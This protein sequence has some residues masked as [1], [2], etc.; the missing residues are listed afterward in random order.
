MCCDESSGYALMPPIWPSR[1]RLWDFGFGE[2]EKVM[3]SV[4]TGERRLRGGVVMNEALNSTLPTAL[5]GVGWSAFGSGTRWPSL[6]RDTSREANCLGVAEIDSRF[7]LA[8][9]RFRLVLV[10]SGEVVS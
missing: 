8:S 3:D 5:E 1:G 9:R 7:G 10:G 4:S 2:G 6:R